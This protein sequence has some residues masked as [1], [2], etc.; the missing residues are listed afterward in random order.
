MPRMPSRPSTLLLRRCSSK[1]ITFPFF[2]PGCEKVADAK[3]DPVGLLFDA[4][5]FYLT[6]TDCNARFKAD[7]QYG[8]VGQT[9]TI[10]QRLPDAEPEDET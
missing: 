4:P 5:A 3:A 8:A 1:V 7:I 6:C 2:C 10:K 9:L